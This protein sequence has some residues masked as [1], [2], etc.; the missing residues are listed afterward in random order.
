MV[1]WFNTIWSVEIIWYY[2]KPGHTYLFNFFSPNKVSLFRSDEA[3]NKN[4][5]NQSLEIN[6]DY[7]HAKTI[8][9]QPGLKSVKVIV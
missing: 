7:S 5:G 1:E 3:G 9:L 6:T 4:Q 2:S 8:D